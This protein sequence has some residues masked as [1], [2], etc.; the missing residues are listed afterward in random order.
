MEKEFIPYKQALALKELGFEEGFMFA[1]YDYNG[2]LTPDK[3]YSIN[4]CSTSGNQAYKGFI[5]DSEQAKLYGEFCSAPTFSQAFRWFREKYGLIGFISFNEKST[6]R[7]ETLPH[8]N[9]K[10]NSYKEKYFD[11]NGKMWNTYEEAELECIKKLI[12]I[13]KNIHVLPTPKPSRLGYIFESEDYHI[14]TNGENPN[15]IADNLANY[16]NIYITSDEE[17]KEGDWLLIIDDF[18]T[19]VHKY[20][21]DNLPTTYH[22]KIILTTDPDLIKDGVQAIPNEFLE[23]FVKNPSCEYVFISNDFEQ[24]NQD[25]PILRGSTNVIHK[26]KIIIPKEEQS[27]I[28]PK[29]NQNCDDEMCDS[30][31][32]CNIDN[33]LITDSKELSFEEISN[34]FHQIAKDYK[35]EFN[36]D[37]TKISKTYSDNQ[38]TIPKQETLEEA[39]ERILNLSEL[40]GFRDFHLRQDLYT[41]FICGVKYEQK[42]NFNYEK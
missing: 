32:N 30:A 17:I 24:V 18:E 3:L 34:Q 5:K 29:T 41:A 10:L 22:K 9:I 13:V 39:A 40:D 7:I 37:E 11:N 21:G 16:R 12:E 31:S 42:K 28:C 8:S 14:F 6:F 15:D 26:Y 4:F 23:W 25:N 36:D 1:H 35:D 33:P 2:K 27:Y 20:K 19:Y 38:E